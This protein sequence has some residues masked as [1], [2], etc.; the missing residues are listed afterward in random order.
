MC[1]NFLAPRSDQLERDWGVTVDGDWP[2]DVHPGDHVP[3]IRRWGIGEVAQREGVLA[4]FGL[5]PASAKVEKPAGSSVNAKTET[6][7]TRSNFKG[8]FLAKQWCIV[9]AHAIYV[10]Y[11]AENAKRS[12]RWKVERSDKSPL[13]IAGVWDRWV[14]DDGRELLSFSILTLNCD[15]HPLL[16]RFY[17]PLTERGEKNEKRTPVLLAEED[18]DEWLGT[19]PGRAAYYFGTF[20][21]DDLNA[22]PAPVPHSATRR[23]TMTMPLD[24]IPSEL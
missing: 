7:A 13:S 9:P 8:A 10:P 12:E 11:W 23:S 1:T 24:S 21:K 19:T 2:T 6:A 4:R 22:E 16:S 3:I 14:G 20:G 17:R 5:L 15:L 18:F